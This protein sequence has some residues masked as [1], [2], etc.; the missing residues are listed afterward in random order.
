MAE[1]KTKDP[2]QGQKPRPEAPVAKHELSDGHAQKASG[3][4]P[5]VQDK[6]SLRP[7]SKLRSLMR[8]AT[9]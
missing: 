8:S 1:E 7:G 9:L 3:G 6:I 2:R 4:L 5:A